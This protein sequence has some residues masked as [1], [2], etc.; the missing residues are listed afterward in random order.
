MSE[1]RLNINCR[2]VRGHQ[3]QT[4]LEV[5]AAAGIYIPTLCHDER[6]KMFG[7][8]GICVVQAEGSP[9]LLRA[10]S[11]MAEDGMVISTD[12]A[13]VRASRTAALELLLSDHT[14]DC[15][16]PCA[17]ACPAQTDCQGYAGL[18]ANGQHLEALKLVKDKV[19]LPAS[20]GRVCPH[21]CEDACRR[22]LVEEPVSI[23]H[24]KQFVGDLDVAR[25]QLY[26]APVG[27]PTGK[28]VAIVGAGPGGLTAAYYLRA[29]GH[30]VSVYDSM[31]QMG[32]MLRYGIPEYR[33]PKKILDAE[34]SAIEGMGIKFLGNIKIGRDVT[35]SFL[36]QTYDA[37]VVA[38]GAWT[39]TG[40]GCLDETLDSVFGGIDFLRDV[41]MHKHVFT[42]RRVVVVGGG[43]TAMDACRTAVR[44]GAEK[45]Y[46]V[47]RR[48]RA[49]MPAQEIE[50]IEAEEEG[51]I[52]KNL[53]NPVGVVAEDGQLK[54]VRLQPQELGEPDAS[55]RRRPVPIVGKDELVECDSIIVA[56]GQ[57]P[58]LEGFDALDKTNWGTIVA[59]ETTFMTN[60][61]GV[62]AVGDATNEGADIAITAI[63]EAGKAA[64]MIGR[65]LNGEQLAYTPQYLAKTEKTADDFA[66]QEKAAR[67]KMPHRAPAVRRTDFLEVNLGLSDRDAKTEAARCLECG[68]QDYFECKLIDLANQ[69]IVHPEKF[70]GK[71][72]RE[73]T[74]TDHPFIHRNPEKCILC[75]LCVRVCDETVGAG[76]LGFLGRG[77]DTLVAPALQAPLRDT[78]CI[79]CGQCVHVCPT[80]ALLEPLMTVKQVPLREDFTQTTC[81]FCSVGCKTKL[82]SKGGLLTRNLPAD[83]HGSLLCAGGRFGFGEI[84][85]KG[86]LAFPLIREENGMVAVG[87][88]QAVIKA[89]KGMQSLQTQYGRQ[90]VAVAVSERYTNEEVFLITRYAR[91]ALG[92][93]NVYSFGKTSS[94]LADVLGRDAST[95]TFDELENAKLIVAV[96]PGGMAKN[97]AAMKIRRAVGRGAKLLLLSPEESLLSAIAEKQL[98]PGTDLRL[99]REIAKAMLDAGRGDGLDNLAKF[100]ASLKDD[101]PGE[102]ATAAAQMILGARSAVFIFERHVLTAGAARLVADIALLSGH[103]QGPRRGVIQLLPGA[104]SQGLSDFGVLPGDELVRD[105]ASGKVR[106]LFIFGED[107]L[108]ADLA[109][110]DFLAVQDLH[111]T[112]TG[113]QAQVIFPAS[114]YAEACGSYTGADG[115]ISELKPAVACPVPWDTV[116]QV[117]SLAAHAGMQMDYQT[118]GD[119]QHDID[120]LPPPAPGHLRL[121]PAG[122]DTLLRKPHVSTNSLSV[123]FRA[124]MATQKL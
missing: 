50:I 53:S 62:F 68:C 64:E 119:V 99:L 85:K 96:A 32:G 70:D 59:D 115:K 41:A 58:E 112:A 34:I 98:D 56:V 60:I 33:L 6:A 45:V 87:F 25:G 104:N 57:K 72:H 122:E 2:E 39:S 18:I 93:N 10:C 9:K 20:I 3:G 66:G 23:C 116:T 13:N 11:I 31:P 35:L 114:S 118:I 52:F 29:Q 69:Y 37:V 110:L 47:Y 49:E 89:N 79:S 27:P 36:R 12:T 105:I 73:P 86:R 24:L 94:G 42:G 17:L 44:L 124:L 76:A 101:S 16:A 106:G 77:F 8:C 103:H 82:A 7:S 120:K 74:D 113:N 14:G 80:G 5:A 92:V 90:C 43:N 61:P 22:E 40:L 48:T 38:V 4:I 15:R 21:P 55:G 81:S 108:E 109:K 71:V 88:E 84:M 1:I 46:N 100:A 121:M 51:V 65:Y 102:D 75:G 63:G 91:E 19:P 107:C 123:S 95:A 54:A 67:V 117:M 83:D 111:M 97:V 28:H 78:D 30:D 26:T